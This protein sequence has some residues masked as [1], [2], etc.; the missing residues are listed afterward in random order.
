MY[1]TL[2]E[3]KG[4]F[5]PVTTLT[6]LF[7]YITFIEILQIDCWVLILYYHGEISRRQK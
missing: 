1:V 4:L 6:H 3:K 7:W 2:L 5:C